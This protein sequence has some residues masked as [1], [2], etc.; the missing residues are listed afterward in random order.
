VHVLPA[1]LEK[2]EKLQAN[3][4]KLKEAVVAFSAGVDSSFLLKSA[5]L[6]LGGKNIR[7]IHAATTVLPSGETGAAE[8]FCSDLGVE[9]TTI[10]VDPLAWPE[11]VKNSPDRCFYCKFRLYTLFQKEAGQISVLDGTNYDDL[12]QDRPGLEAIRRLGIKTPLADAGLTKEEIRQLSRKLS[13]TTSEL[14]SSSCLATRVP[15]GSFITKERIELIKKCEESLNS[16]GFYGVRVRVDSDSVAQVAVRKMDIGRI[17][18]KNTRTNIC[19][20][21]FELGVKRVFFMK[22][23]RPN[24]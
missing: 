20:R 18:E 3:I 16:L 11:F 9:L 17:F 24:L 8:K 6:V 10:D 5:H 7:A 4:G 12:F 23:G 14:C 1:T 15:V 22:D 2:F 21:F 13:L 19:D